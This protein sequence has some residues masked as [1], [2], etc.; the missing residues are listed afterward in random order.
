[1]DL[2]GV[3]NHFIFGMDLHPYC[4]AFTFDEPIFVND[5][6]LDETPFVAF[7]LRGVEPTDKSTDVP[8]KT[9]IGSRVAAIEHPVGVVSRRTVAAT[10]P[11]Q[12]PVDFALPSFDVAIMFPEGEGAEFFARLAILLQEFCRSEVLELQGRP[13]WLG[14]NHW[15]TTKG[16]RTGA[17]L[18]SRQPPSKSPPPAKSGISRDVCRKLAAEQWRVNAANCDGTE[19]YSQEPEISTLER[20]RILL[21]RG[22]NCFFLIMT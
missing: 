11:T 16:M 4:L 21:L 20:W 15:R 14:C 22:G 6:A 1:M 3:I 10:F 2:P 12:I 19:T 8:R 13:A 17:S 5:R 9:E 18:G 7:E